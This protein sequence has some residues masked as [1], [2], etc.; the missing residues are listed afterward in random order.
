MASG[1]RRRGSALQQRSGNDGAAVGSRLLECTE[2]WSGG[3]CFRSRRGLPCSVPGGVTCCSMWGHSDCA[4]DRGHRRKRAGTPPP[5]HR[6]PSPARPPAASLDQTV[7]VWDI[8]GLRKK[9]AAPG[10]DDALRMPQVGGCRGEPGGRGGFS[11]AHSQAAGQEL[12]LLVSEPP[13]AIL[14]PPCAD[15]C[16]PLWRRRRGGQVRGRAAAQDGIPQAASSNPA[17]PASPTSLSPMLCCRPP[18]AGMCW[19]VMTAASTGPLSIPACRSSCRA[20]TTAR[21][22]SGA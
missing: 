21:S 17:W 8:S 10:A 6:L 1:E 20:L 4:G 9:G 22:S 2:V 15:E 16:G 13:S 19:R 18:P 5:A 12:P 11:E 7:R 3:P 14:C